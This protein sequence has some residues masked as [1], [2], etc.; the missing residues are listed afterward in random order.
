VYPDDVDPTTGLPIDTEYD[1]TTGE[2]IVTEIDGDDLDLNAG[3]IDNQTGEA[4]IDP[5]TGEQVTL[6]D[7]AAEGDVY[8]YE[9]D[10]Y[11]SW[12]EYIEGYVLE[13]EEDDF[14]CDYWNN[15]CCDSDEEYW[16]EAD[17]SIVCS[18]PNAT[19]AA[20]TTGDGSGVT[21]STSG[22]TGSTSG[23]TDSTSAATSSP[24]GDDDCAETP[25]G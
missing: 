6:G 12:C 18:D 15:Y 22:A 17:G 10:Y 1:P 9:C 3:L 16:W 4:L 14:N 7:L 25:E 11:N 20:G 23:V 13:Y 19:T 8:L 5:V 24:S 21:D 2:P